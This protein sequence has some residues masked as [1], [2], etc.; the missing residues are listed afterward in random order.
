[1]ADLTEPN[2]TILKIV[3]QQYHN[4]VEVPKKQQTQIAVLMT[5]SLVDPGIQKTAVRIQELERSKNE[6]KE[7]Y[8]KNGYSVQTSFSGGDLGQL[9]K[10]TLKKDGK[11]VELTGEEFDELKKI[12]DKRASQVKGLHLD[13]LRIAAKDDLSAKV[14]LRAGTLLYVIAC[15]GELDRKLLESIETKSPMSETQMNSGMDEK[16]K[17]AIAAFGGSN[18]DLSSAGAHG[19]ISVSRPHKNQ[20]KVDDF[21]R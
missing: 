11:A 10:V 7:K 15:S 12:Y 17:R 4:D 3:E 18:A 1:M 5:R 13:V 14:A 16:M 20:G 6:Y 21:N 8:R 19:S 9:T 2:E